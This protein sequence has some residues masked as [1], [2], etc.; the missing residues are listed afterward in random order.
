MYTYKNKVTGAVIQTHG[1]VS[2]TNW[3]QV[4]EKAKTK[5]AKEEKESDGE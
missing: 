4:K 5:A 3:E 1:K 2:G